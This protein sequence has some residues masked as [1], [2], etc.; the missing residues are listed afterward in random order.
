MKQRIIFALIMGSATKAIISYT[1]N[2]F[3]YGPLRDFFRNMVKILEHI[4]GHGETLSESWRHQ[5][6]L[7]F[8][9]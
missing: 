3:E 8:T 2:L 1:L 4:T 6:R 7:S 5:S 9:S